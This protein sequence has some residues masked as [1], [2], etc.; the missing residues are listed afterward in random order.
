MAKEKREALR[1]A[2]RG[3]RED[4]LP[5]TLPRNENW[6]VRGWGG[7]SGGKGE[8]EGPERGRKNQ[9][10]TEGNSGLRGGGLRL[11][12]RTGLG[13]AWPTR[14]LA[15]GWQGWVS[16]DWEPGFGERRSAALRRC[17]NIH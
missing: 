4:K 5:G 8:R 11:G 1:A 13:A 12:M 14:A 9:E 17:L 7:T 16:W 3:M 6:G 10:G 15:G 2:A